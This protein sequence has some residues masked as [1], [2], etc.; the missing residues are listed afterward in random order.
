MVS[1]NVEVVDA[2]TSGLLH[3]RDELRAGQ[4]VRLRSGTLLALRYGGA[5][6]R[7]N[8]NA[9]VVLHPNQLELVRG[10]IYVDAGPAVA[11]TIVT[12]FGTL[13]HVG[14]QFLVSV[15]ETE[16]RA[17]VREGAVEID[18]I[19]QRKTI[20]A[21]EG[22]V[23]AAIAPDGTLTVQ[24]IASSGGP[25][26]WVVE[27]TPGYTIDGRSA[28]ELLVWATRQLGTKL[29]YQTEATRIHSR[30]VVLHGGIRAV[31][32]AQGLAVL[33]AATDLDIDQSD[34]AVLHVRTAKTR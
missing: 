10:D 16:V 29:N 5:D 27:A 23:A 28:D 21:A 26:S 3:E 30:S 2:R 18:S 31:S 11:L 34:P 12:P 6:V 17:A 32:V 24:A 8:S 14:T 9:V 20:K 15:T 25:W 13:T 33:R 1:G 19:S 7:L 4:T 22:A